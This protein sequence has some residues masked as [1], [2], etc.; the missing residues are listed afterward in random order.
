MNRY[1]PGMLASMLILI[2][3]AFAICVGLSLMAWRRWR[4]SDGEGPL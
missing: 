4:S 1:M 3:P 2:V